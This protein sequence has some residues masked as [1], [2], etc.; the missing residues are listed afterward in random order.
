[1]RQDYYMHQRFLLNCDYESV[2]L[3]PA[4]SF[5]IDDVLDFTYQPEL[6]DDKNNITRKVKLSYL[7]KDIDNNDDLENFICQISFANNLIIENDVR[8]S[9]NQI[10][11]DIQEAT[12]K[13]FYLRLKE[14]KNVSVCEKPLIDEDQIE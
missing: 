14:R 13:S 6:F 3:P 9:S 4:P 7:F 8:L 10:I 5:P 12:L 11:S 2:I 1:M